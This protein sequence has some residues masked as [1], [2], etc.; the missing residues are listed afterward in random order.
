MTSTVY[1]LSRAGGLLNKSHSNLGN[2]IKYGDHK[3]FDSFLENQIN[4]SLRLSDIKSA[5]YQ[6]YTQYL[7][8]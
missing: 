8:Y 3:I 5:Y 2:G 7:V 1:V 6:I 4:G